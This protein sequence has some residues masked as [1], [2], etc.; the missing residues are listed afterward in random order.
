MK[1]A[2]AA[3]VA[4]ACVGASSAHAA[5]PAGYVPEATAWDAAFSVGITY[6]FNDYPADNIDVSANCRRIT[7]RWWHCDVELRAHRTPT[8]RI[9]TMVRRRHIAGA[10]KLRVTQQAPKV[11]A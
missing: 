10:W 9:T 5:R 4:L 11:I 7:A 6:G 1:L 3:F 2:T 8:I